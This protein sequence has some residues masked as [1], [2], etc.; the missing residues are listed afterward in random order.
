MKIEKK[1]KGKGKGKAIIGIVMAAIM[2]ATLMAMVPA[3]T[4]RPTAN[5]IDTTDV[6]Y[7]GEQGLAFD[8][9]Q[10][11]DYGDAGTFD[12]FAILEGVPD[13]ATEGEPPLCLSATYTV[14]DVTEGKYYFDANGNGVLDAGEF[15]I[16]VDTAEISGDIILNNAGQ[17]SIVGKSVPTS[18]EIVFKARMTFGGKI[19]WG[20]FKIVVT[21]PDGVVIETIDG[22][23]LR[24]LDATLGTSV[25]VGDATAVATKGVTITAPAYADAIDLAGMDTGTYKVEIKTEKHTCNML[26]V[27]SAEMEF[28]LRSEEL[29][30]EAEKDT[31]YKGED[32]VLKVTGG[33]MTYYYLIVTDIDTTAPP[34]IKDTSDVKAL[35]ATGAAYP[36]W[37]PTPNLAAWIKTDINGVADVK[38]STTGADERTY[39]I[40]VY[41]TTAVLNPAQA[42]GPTFA[43]DDF[44]DYSPFTMDNDDVDVEVIEPEV[45]FDIPASVVVGEEVTIKG[46]ISAGDYVDIVI[47]GVYLMVD[48]EPVDENNEF[49]VNWDTS[50]L[51]TGS[52]RIDVYIDCPIWGWDPDAYEDIDA[53]GSTTIRILEPELAAK[54]PQNAVAEDDDY[55]I[56]GIA[57]GVDDVDIVL[58]GP[59]GYPPGNPYL[60][61]LND[62][63][64]IASSVTADEFS[65]DVTMME[66]VNT[67]TWITMVFSPGRDGEYGSTG[68]TAGNLDG[69]GTFQFAGKT[70][71]QIV[72]IL[73]DYTIDVAGSDDLLVQFTFEVET[74]YVKFEPIESVT[75][76]EPLEI[77]GKTNREPGTIIVISTY[78]GPTNLPMAITEVEWPTPYQG[79]FNATIDTTYAVA[80]TYTLEADDGD[81]HTDKATVEILPPKPPTPEVSLFTDKREYSPGDVMKTNIRI[82]NPT[83][84]IQKLS[85][86]WYLGIPEYDLWAEMAAMPVN[87]PAGYDQ[88]FTVPIPVGDWG[89]ESFCGFHIASLTNTTTKKVVSVDSTAW[90]YMPDAV[91]ES[92]TAAEIEKEITKEIEGVEL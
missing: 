54:Q 84:D 41:D 74:P 34:A 62:L 73:K 18:A 14:P 83:D 37:P 46:T 9:D 90:I 89:T 33:L 68:L 20:E 85:L 8:V 87:L 72:A 56:E 19:P 58:V 82:S 80:G 57:T 5:Q 11:G 59:I 21:D 16:Y 79:V 67:G 15:Y 78:A 76:G 28:T 23:D 4:A 77:T 35:D 45:T 43:P 75:V 30:I 13:T 42:G 27:S 6:I 92:K 71:S 24:H 69:I 1:G 39:T 81:G 31:V 40:K 36:S 25:Y 91:S 17:D 7:I 66:G 12:V 86:K 64:I 63:D 38:I 44:V 52:Y 48:D 47:P 88:M 32:I 51:F 53:D 55:T 29:S 61:V 3:G 65:E 49:E 70:Q 26:D 10:D 2:L 22:Q 50:G 60:G